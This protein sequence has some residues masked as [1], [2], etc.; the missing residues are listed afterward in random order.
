LPQKARYDVY[1]YLSKPDIGWRRTNKQTMYNFIVHHDDGVDKVN[2]GSEE[3][4]PGWVLI[5][6]YSFSSDTAMVELTNNSSGEMVFADAVKWV[7]T[8]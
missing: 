1:F 5:G 8:K 4:E 2:R 3:A 6:N 7:L